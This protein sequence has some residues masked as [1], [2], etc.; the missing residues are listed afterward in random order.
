MLYGE[1]F[2]KSLVVNPQHDPLAQ[3]AEHFHGSARFAL[4]GLTSPPFWL[5][6][7]GLVVAWYL[8]LKRPELPGR[9]AE[10]LRAPYTLLTRKYYFDEFYD[11]VFA[12]GARLIGSGLWRF[13]DVRVIDGFFVNGS[14]RAVGW[15]AGVIRRFRSGYVYHYAFIMIIGV[16]V[17]LTLWFARA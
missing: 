15:F 6:I 12:G 1:L 11:R 17:L 9:I 7:A 2:K 13:G 8:Y 5:A 16:L 3:L 14:A 4:H 10:W